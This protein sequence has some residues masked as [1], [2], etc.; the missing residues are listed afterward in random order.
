M[1]TALLGY[2]VLAGLVYYGVKGAWE[3]LKFAC[4]AVVWVVGALFTV[5]G[6]LT[7][8]ILDTF[9]GNPEYVP[10]SA[11]VSKVNP[12]LDFIQD[13]EAKGLIDS[14][15]E[16][17][18][19]KRRLRDA[20]REGETI[21]MTKVRNSQGKEGIANPRF[22]KAERGFESRIQDALDRGQ[23]YEKAKI[24]VAN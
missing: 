14:D 21:I 12:L 17:L 7:D 8:Y 15:G 24:K 5:V 19:I 2:V 4:N 1:L 9:E 18:Q 16:V 13:Q 23:I 3:L 22:V 11:Y 6:A 20:A 10:E